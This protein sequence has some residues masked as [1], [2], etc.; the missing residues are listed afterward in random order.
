MIMEALRGILADSLG[1]DESE[2]TPGA[3]LRCD[4][5]LSDSDLADVLD[6]LAGELGFV[7]EESDLDTLTTVSSL[8]RY[9]SARA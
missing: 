8:V 5:G 1:C 6:A 2:I 9:A 7:Y 3:D 4:L